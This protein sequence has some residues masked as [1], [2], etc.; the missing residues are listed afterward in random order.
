MLFKNG[1][2]CF[3]WVSGII[4]FTKKWSFHW[5]SGIII[6]KVIFP[7]SLWNYDSTDSVERSLFVMIPLSLWNHNSTDSVESTTYQ[8]VIFPL[9]LWNHNS[10]DSVESTVQ[11]YLCF[12]DP[13]NY[14]YNESSYTIHW[15]PRDDNDKDKEKDKDKMIKRPN[16]CHIFENDVT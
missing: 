13:Y 15:C 9:C 1:R 16:I 6:K 5:L 3:H 10:T 7:L 2:G 14:T 4:T 8:K 11:L 12:T